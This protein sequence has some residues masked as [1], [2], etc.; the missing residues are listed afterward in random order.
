MPALGCAARGR[1][2]AARTRSI[3][4]SIATGPTLQ[5][6]PSDVHVPFR[7]A[8]AKCFRVGAV[9]AVSVFI[10]R[11]MR[12]DRNLRIHIAAGEDGLMQFFEIAKSLE[13]QQID[14][15]LDQ[16][17]NLIAKRRASFFERSLAE[18][19][20]ANAERTNRACDPDIETFRRLASHARA[21][22][23]DVAHTIGQAVPRQA[24][25]VSAET[26]WSR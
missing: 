1:E 8:C 3:A 13:H 12:N 5:L 19:L 10:D 14:A 25:A 22:Q 16:G 21:R 20:D 4:S 11:D 15:A 18:R 7:Q 24:K 17:R 23:I 9:E 6:M 26:C 2:V